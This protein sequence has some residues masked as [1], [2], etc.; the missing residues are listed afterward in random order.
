[1]ETDNKEH[2][3]ISVYINE[4]FTEKQRTM[5]KC[6]YFFGGEEGKLGA[7]GIRSGTLL[8]GR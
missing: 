8:D 3:K 4:D 1:M 5:A 2:T 6:S 7:L